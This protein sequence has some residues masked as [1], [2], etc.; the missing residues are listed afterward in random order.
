MFWCHNKV[1]PVFGD[2]IKQ[3]AIRGFLRRS[4]DT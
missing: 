2:G 3:F 1:A 4:V